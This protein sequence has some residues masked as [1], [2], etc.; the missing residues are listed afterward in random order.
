MQFGMELERSFIRA[1]VSIV[2]LFQEKHPVQTVC[3]KMRTCSNPSE[4]H[5]QKET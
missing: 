2:C 1:R 3:T 5:I 4:K